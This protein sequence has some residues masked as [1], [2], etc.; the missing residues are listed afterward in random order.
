M[1]Q[2]PQFHTYNHRLN[3]HLTH[4]LEQKLINTKKLKRK[5]FGGQKLFFSK[6]AERTQG[7]AHLVSQFFF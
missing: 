1:I 6:N 7:K 4:G 3:I 2:I 5:L